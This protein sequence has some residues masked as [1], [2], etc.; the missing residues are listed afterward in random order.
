M[1]TFEEFEQHLREALAHLYDPTYQ[2]PELL[3]LITESQQGGRVESVQAAIIQAIK[4]LKP[5]ADVPPSARIRRVYDLLAYRYIQDLTQEEAAQR[6]GITPRHLRREQQQAIDV[7]AR[8]LWEQRETERLLKNKTTPNKS[9]TSGATKAEA[10]S[11]AWH[12]QVKKELVSLQRSA[13]GIIADVGE[14]MQAAVK[15]TCA[16]TQKHQIEL[17]VEPISPHLTA[18]I[19][20]SILHQLLITAI[21][22]LIQHMSSG[23]I[24]LWASREAKNVKIVVSGRPISTDTPPNSDLMREIM[25]TCQ[26]SIEVR[27]DNKQTSFYLGLPS[28]EEIRVLVIDDNMDLVHFYRRYIAGTRYQIVHV[29]KGQHVFEI[30]ETTPPDIIVLDVMLPDI[31]GWEL[32]AQLQEQPLTQSIP[33]VVCS[34]VRREAVALALGAALY[35]PKPVRRRQ[36]IQ[37]LDQV[38]LRL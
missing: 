31:D 35:L 30:V 7:L 16:L 23:Q 22:K 9:L 38:S 21:E 20:P 24:T 33:I 4:D 10:D 19:H 18:A 15:L 25:T 26:G 36:F 1:G 2:P 5:P 6:L 13:P 8:R 37:G 17:Q 11:E 34:V 12:S 28:A 3:W 14:A 29:A 32:L 27:L